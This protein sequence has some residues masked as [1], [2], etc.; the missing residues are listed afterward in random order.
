[1]RSHLRSRVWFALSVVSVRAKFLELLGASAFSVCRNTDGLCSKHAAAAAAAVAATEV[2]ARPAAAAARDEPPVA[3][4]AAPVVQPQTAAAAPEQ[5]KKKNRCS[6]CK[7]KV[8]LLGFECKC[9]RLLCA[10]HR[11]AEE[12]SCEH[13]YRTEGKKRLAEANPLVAFSKIDSI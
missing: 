2:D 11:T 3:P 8:G 10:S 6:V 12:H 4:A 7:K 5:P 1:M 13:D 9:G